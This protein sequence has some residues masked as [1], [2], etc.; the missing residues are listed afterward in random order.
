MDKVLGIIVAAV[1]LLMTGFTLITMANDTFG[2]FGEE[3]SQGED[4]ACDFQVQ[5]VENNPDWID[6]VSPECR[7][8]VEENTDI[9]EE[10]SS[11]VD[12]GLGG[13]ID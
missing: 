3:T 8:E 9:S 2:T 6:N 11:L 12:E 10:R 7:D 1:V 13:L 5:Q 4:I